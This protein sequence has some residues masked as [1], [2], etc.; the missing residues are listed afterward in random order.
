VRDNSQKYRIPAPLRNAVNDFH[1]DKSFTALPSTLRLRRNSFLLTLA[2]D[3]LNH[4]DEVEDRN[5]R[6]YR[7][8]LMNRQNEGGLPIHEILESIPVALL[9]VSHRRKSR[10]Q[11]RELNPR[12]P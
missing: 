3:C 11:K 9:M 10:Q 1:V 8:S 2:H 5:K 4:L 6:G 12:S 7:P